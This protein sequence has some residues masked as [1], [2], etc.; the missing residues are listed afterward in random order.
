MHSRSGEI[1]GLKAC[2]SWKYA[3][4]YPKPL[5]QASAFLVSPRHLYARDAFDKRRDPDLGKSG[6]QH[7]RMELELHDMFF[8]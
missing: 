8:E 6:L 2:A 1:F 7:Q 4:H 5:H 3:C